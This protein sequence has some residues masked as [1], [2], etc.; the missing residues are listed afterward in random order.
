MQFIETN[1]VGFDDG[2]TEKNSLKY[3]VVFGL[4]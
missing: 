2:A 4:D 3:R 1:K